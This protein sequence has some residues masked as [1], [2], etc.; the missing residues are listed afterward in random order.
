MYKIPRVLVFCKV[1]HWTLLSLVGEVYWPAK[2]KISSLE[3]VPTTVTIVQHDGNP[4][5]IITCLN[6]FKC[7][8]LSAFPPPPFRPVTVIISFSV[9]LRVCI[10]AIGILKTVVLAHFWGINGLESSVIV[11]HENMVRIQVPHQGLICRTN[12]RNIRELYTWIWVSEKTTVGETF[13]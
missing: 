11:A 4:V 5:S 7:L 8:I 10:P 6:K 13:L 1:R 2:Q 3:N 9:G 12:W